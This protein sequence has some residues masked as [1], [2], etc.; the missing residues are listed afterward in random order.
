MAN[1]TYTQKFKDPRWQKKR[2]EI[3]T[4]DEFTC[5]QCDN[6][7]E[8]LHVHHLYYVNGRNPWDYPMFAMVTLCETCHANL[9]NKS[10]GIMDPALQ[11][12]ERC[13]ENFY[14]H[15]QNKNVGS[16]DF[17]FMD[18]WDLGESITSASDRSGIPAHWVIRDA[19]A[20][21]EKSYQ[22]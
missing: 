12:W 22:K 4:R 18:L 21:I 7:D 16:V 13:L 3:M 11:D 20:F 6:T 19:M 10:N 8:C 15:A 9:P 2:L 14:N 5:T 17:A 1:T